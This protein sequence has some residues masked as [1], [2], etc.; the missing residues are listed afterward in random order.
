MQLIAGAKLDIGR[1]RST[2]QDALSSWADETV[3]LF[4]VA[5]GV[6]G[7]AAGD[8]ASQL[9]ID[10]LVPALR[11]KLEE[12]RDGPQRPSSPDVPGSDEASSPQPLTYERR[13]VRLVN[14]I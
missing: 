6:G 9:A 11:P 13:L 3:G 14:H 5:D 7:S 2:N 8:I 10:T 1:T 12:M 4:I